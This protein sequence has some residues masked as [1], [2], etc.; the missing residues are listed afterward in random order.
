M[1]GFSFDECIGAVGR[2]NEMRGVRRGQLLAAMAEQ[3][4]EGTVQFSSAVTAVSQTSSGTP[5]S[6]NRGHSPS[7]VYHCAAAGTS[8]YT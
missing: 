2:N 6:T 1:K 5:C 8:L 3:L 7:T 4:P